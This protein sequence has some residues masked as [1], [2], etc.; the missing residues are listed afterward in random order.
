MTSLSKRLWL[1]WKALRGKLFF[2]GYTPK[3]FWYSHR[4]DRLEQQF[5]PTPAIETVT[6][7]GM[8]QRVDSTVRGAKIVFQQAEVDIA[9][10]LPDLVRIDWKPGIPP[11]P[12]GIDRHEWDAVQVDLTETADG[13]SLCCQGNNTNALTVEVGKQ[14]DFRF[15]DRTG[16][17][18]R[19]ELPPQKPGLGWTHQAKLRPEEHV[20]GLGERAVPLN[21]RSAKQLNPQGEPTEKPRAL[22]LWNFDAAGQVWGW[23]P[24]RST[25]GIPV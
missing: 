19:E 9:F 1:Q 6:E 20:Y 23:E 3:A 8:V 18:L 17:L 2:L 25:W 16:Q 14:G 11:V 5:P 7:L 13:W 21:L 24:T 15:L 22:R 12:Y 10:L 4:R